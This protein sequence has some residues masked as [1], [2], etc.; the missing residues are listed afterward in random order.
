MWKAR[1]EPGFQ[2]DLGEPGDPDR[3]IVRYQELA[4]GETMPARARGDWYGGLVLGGSIDVAGKTLVRD[5]VLIA[6]RGSE[7][8]EAVAGKD[9]VQ[10]L[11]HMRTARAL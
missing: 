8:P 7:I 1:L 4:P 10:I 5:D 6:A 3:G 2:W 9:G 11:E